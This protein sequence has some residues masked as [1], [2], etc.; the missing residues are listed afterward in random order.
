M[1]GHSQFANIKHRKEAQ[2]NKRAKIFTK[3][4]REIITSAKL[5]SPDPE[6]NARLRAA[7]LAARAKNIPKDRIQGAINRG[8]SQDN[9]DHF[10][11]MRYEGYGPAAT[12][13]IVEALT[14]N[15]NRTISDVRS[16]FTKA[17]GNIGE[18]GSVNF[19]FDRLGIIE[20]K[21]SIGSFDNILE[22]SVEAGAND[23][24]EAGESYFI[25]T[26]PEE[27]HQ[28][29]EFIT[30]KFGDPDQCALI[31]KPKNQ[32]EI[33]E[34]ED[35]KKLLKFIDALEDNDDVQK[36]FYNFTFDDKVMEELSK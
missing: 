13:I 22:V 17:G 19:M 5:G 9:A 18:S 26:L 3:L 29:R 14:D 31:W 36:V 33:C 6:A 7:I 23:C 16:V 15:R 20:F 25:Y 4:L 1:A 27:L 2:D 12:A 35:A 11:E 34:V 8:S 24:E 30:K 32:V 28:I 10:E 21:K